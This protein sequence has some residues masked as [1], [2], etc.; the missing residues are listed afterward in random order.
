LINSYRIKKF[1]KDSATNQIRSQMQAGT[2]EFE[3]IDMAIA[4]LHNKGIIAFNDGLMY[5][6][7]EQYYRELTGVDK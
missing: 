5:V 4:K 2:G 7:D 3:S 1:I 6:E